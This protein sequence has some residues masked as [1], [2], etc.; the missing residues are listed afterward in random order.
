MKTHCFITN[1]KSSE[2]LSEYVHHHDNIYPEVTSGLR[3]AGVLSLEINVVPKTLTLIMTITTRANVD[4]DA[5]LGPG[6]AYREI[7]RCKEWEELMD[8]RFHGGWDKCEEIHSSEN[9]G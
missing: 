4:L 9:W 2:L 5:A 3:S 6:S 7:A 1:I 8:S